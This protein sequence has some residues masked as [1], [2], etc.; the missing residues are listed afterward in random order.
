VSVEVE[1]GVA[2]TV[3]GRTITSAEL[4][5]DVDEQPTV[6]RY[7]TFSF[8]S[9]ERGADD[10]GI[11]LKD[12]DSPVLR[13]FTTV[14][15]FPVDARWRVA[16]SFEPYVPPR[17]ITVPTA[18]G[19]T[20][21]EVCGGAVVFQLGGEEQRLDAIVDEGGDLFLIFADPSN[22]VTTYGGGR[23]LYADAPAG[24]GAVTLDFNMSVNPPC[25]SLPM[26]PARCR[27]TRTGSPSPSK[28]ARSVTARA[29]TDLWAEGVG[30]VPT[31]SAGRRSALGQA[32]GNGVPALEAV[33]EDQRDETAP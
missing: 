14:D 6:L 21:E 25:A 7:G 4:R 31:S 27:R 29:I 28:P 9:I 20:T 10:V 11:R 17:T 19:T 1:P 26:Q 8:F 15:S 30:R 2:I 18:Y 16:G 5:S 23:F 3:D 12:S 24:A 22:E 33:G 32:P 13:A